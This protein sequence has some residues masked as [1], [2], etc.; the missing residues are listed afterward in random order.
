[1]STTQ[2]REW[3]PRTRSTDFYTESAMLW[4]EADTLIRS[5]THGAK[6]LDDFCRLFY[7]PPSTAPK[8]VP[9]EFN[10][11]VKALNAVMPYDW[12]GFWNLRLNR[13][14]ADAPLEGLTASGWRLVFDAEP[15]LAEK[16]DAALQKATNLYYSLGLTLK[17]EGTVIA[18][19]VPGTPADAAGIAPDSN[20]IAID[21]RKYSKD[22]L[23]DALKAG[24]TEPRALRLLIQK[25]D[26][27]ETVEVHYT[28]H[29]RYPRLERDTS[30]PDL[31]TRI[32]SPRTQ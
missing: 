23:Q 16:G 3:R 27:F 10:D 20:L 21:G 9:Y 22:V 30:T 14:Q 17:D 5:T 28:G 25:D 1:V 32:L 13:V 31:L 4:L 26:V 24:G 6:S 18:D 12:R 15:S 19:V 8:V 2:A 29:A 7:G 11:V